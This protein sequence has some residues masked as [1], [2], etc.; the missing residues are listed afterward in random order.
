MRSDLHPLEDFGLK[1]L[2]PSGPEDLCDVIST[3]YERDSLLTSSRAPGERPELMGD[4]LLS[5]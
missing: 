2:R 3:R 5:L 4:S 1:P